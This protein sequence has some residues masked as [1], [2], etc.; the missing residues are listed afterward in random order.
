MMDE[1]IVNETMAYLRYLARMGCTG[2]DPPAEAVAMTKRWES[3]ETAGGAGGETLEA[4]RAELGD[5]RRCR[6]CERRTRIVFG[7]GN[8]D[9]RIFFV[10]EGPGAEED[11]QGIPFVGAA[12]D[13]LTR[14]ISAMTL[15]REDVY[16]AN[17]VKCRPPGNRNPQ[18]DEIAVCVP[19]LHRQI[20]AVR[21][22]YIIALGSFAAKTLLDTDRPI[23]ALRGRFF[24]FGEARLMPTYHPAYLLRNPD[25]KRDVWDD[26]KKVMAARGLAIDKVRK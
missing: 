22:E 24:D 23:S 9:A 3:G 21:P 10:G 18:P 14:I 6:L 25:R 5:C 1:A 26:I 20:A 13:L 8:S 4:I 2:F 17:I 16:I 15:S 7:E 11:R 19:F 12:G